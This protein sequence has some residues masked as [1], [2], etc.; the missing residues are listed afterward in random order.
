MVKMRNPWGQGEWKGDFCD[1]SAKWT[2][3]LTEKLRHESREDGVFW[4][5][6]RDFLENFRSLHVCRIFS[7]DVYTQKV[8]TRPPRHGAS[9]TSGGRAVNVRTACP[10]TR[11]SIPP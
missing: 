9:L 11:G 3:R 6:F 7:K 2:A 5:Q 10:G 4:M 1:G 8:R